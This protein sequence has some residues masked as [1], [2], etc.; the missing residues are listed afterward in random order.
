MP[1][2]GPKY[3]E[4]ARPARNA[5][6]HP[7]WGCQVGPDDPDFLQP[8]IVIDMGSDIDPLYI[9]GWL[10]EGATSVT[11]RFMRR[12]RWTQRGRRTWIP[13]QA[14]LGEGMQNVLF[15]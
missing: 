13:V 4:I 14:D 6:V 12:G 3:W 11:V 15:V 2:F 10:P 8:A 1:I 9:F 5:I 7:S